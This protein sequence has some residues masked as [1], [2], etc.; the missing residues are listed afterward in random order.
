MRILDYVHLRN[1]YRSTGV[2]RVARELTEHLAQRPDVDLRILADRQD[3]TTIVPK[4]GSPW[5]EY[6]YCFFEKETSR[7]QMWWYLLNRPYAED[8]WPEA[9]IVYCTAESYVP[10]RRAR[11]AVACHDMQLFEPEAHPMSR[12]LLQQ[13]LKWHLLFGQLSESAHMIHTISAFSAGRIAHFFPALEDRLRVIPNAVSPAFFAPPTT[14]GKEVYT[15][16]GLSESPYV[17]V[18]GGLHH[19]KNAELILEAWPEMHRRRPELKLVITSHNTPI[20]LE[21]A[22]LLPSIVTTGF[23][24]E[25]ALVAL[26]HGAELVWFPSKYEGFGMPVVEAMACGAAVVASNSSAI[27]EIAGGAAAVLLPPDR[28]GEH[29]EAVLGLLADQAA[30]QKA[31]ELGRRRAATFTWERSAEL[32]VQRFS[33]LH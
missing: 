18:P 11:L 21:R 22:K 16:L 5:T 28:P 19:R 2:G 3:Y 1:I 4:V 6:S 8:Y 20:Y 32:L 33:E 17:L 27:P 25:D 14:Q 31:G 9:E 24:E 12:W 23:Q 10:T 13:R 7:Q 15:R 30:R 29:V 26:Y